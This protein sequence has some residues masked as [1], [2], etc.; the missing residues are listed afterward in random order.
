MDQ[1]EKKGGEGKF[2]EPAFQVGEG[3][4][5]CKLADCPTHSTDSYFHN[6]VFVF[7]SCHDKYQKLQILKYTAGKSSC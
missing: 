7:V 5:G 1:S 4:G 2:Q 3:G 6:V